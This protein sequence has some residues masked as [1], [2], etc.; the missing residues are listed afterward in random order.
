MTFTIISTMTSTLVAVRKVGRPK[1]YTDE[2]SRN[3][4]E[5]RELCIE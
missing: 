5:N 1:I 4:G 2:K 3:V